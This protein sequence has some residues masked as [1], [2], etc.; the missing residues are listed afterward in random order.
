MKNVGIAIAAAKL[1]ESTTLPRASVELTT[2]GINVAGPWDATADMKDRL[3]DTTLLPLASVEATSTGTTAA[4]L[5]SVA[6]LPCASVA[7]SATRIEVV[8]VGGKTSDLAE[9]L[10]RVLVVVEDGAKWKGDKPATLPF[11]RVGTSGGIAS[12]AGNA[13]VGMCAWRGCGRVDVLL[14][15]ISPAS[16]ENELAVRYTAGCNAA[17]PWR[18]FGPVLSTSHDHNPRLGNSCCI[19]SG[20]SGTVG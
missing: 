10:S 11:E 19:M 8:E 5:V 14:G 18:N 17:L 2:N 1:F 16:T 6:D 7:V 3:G 9:A 15:S 12:R 13:E 20:S 4:R